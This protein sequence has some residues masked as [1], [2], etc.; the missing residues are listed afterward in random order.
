MA[1]AH[2]RLADSLAQPVS[3]RRRFDVVGLSRV[4]RH[5]P[6]RSTAALVAVALV[7]LAAGSTACS[8]GGAEESDP[9]V[10]VS[11][12][13]GVTADVRVLDNRFVP[14][15]LIVEPGTEVRFVNAGRND[16]NVIPAEEPVEGGFDLTIPTEDLL[17][18]MEA[19]VRFTEPGA[20]AYYCAIHGTAKA[21]MIGTIVVEG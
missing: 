6:A 18:G 7:A 10:P 20:Y 5:A 14:A 13:E 11:L 1:R 9:T 21:G 4:A 8:G 19:S 16:H 3:V 12:V 17:V 15:E 2:R